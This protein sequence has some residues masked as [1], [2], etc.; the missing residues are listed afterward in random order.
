MQGWSGVS[1]DALWWGGWLGRAFRP[2]FVWMYV[3]VNVEFYQLQIQY[4][5]ALPTFFS[6]NLLPPVLTCCSQ[7]LSADLPIFIFS[8]QLSHTDASR[9]QEPNSAWAVGT[10]TRHSRMIF[11]KQQTFKAS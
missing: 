1:V 9:S 8:A 7:I 2:L 11:V 3:S 6:P 10:E 5:H 4:M